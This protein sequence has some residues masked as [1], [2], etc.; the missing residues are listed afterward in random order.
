M[1]SALAYADV[2]EPPTGSSTYLHVIPITPGRPIA[3]QRSE[4]PQERS[5]AVH[6]I[7]YSIQRDL[8]PSFTDQR[9][10]DVAGTIQVGEYE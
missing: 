10:G 9:V 4:Y 3:N 8:R 1:A 6:V 2:D 5:E 7:P